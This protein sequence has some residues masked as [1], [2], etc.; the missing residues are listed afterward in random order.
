MLRASYGTSFTAPPIS[1][2]RP[3]T[4]VV[5]AVLIYPQFNNQT[6]PDQR[7]HGRE[8]RPAAGD[9]QDDLHVGFVISPSQLPGSS[10]TVE[11]FYV[12]QR[13]VVLV[14]DPQAIVDGTFPGNGHFHALANGRQSTPSRAMSAVATCRAS[15]S[16]STR[17]YADRQGRNLWVQILRGLY[18]PVRRR[19]RLGFHERT[20]VS[21]RTTCSTSA[22]SAR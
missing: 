4:Q 21:S 15:T 2:L 16:T 9:R 18:D 10:L 3:Q 1:L 13:N 7:D 17:R 14:P 8:S 20:R 12:R 5:N 19:Q 6:I 22:A 11:H